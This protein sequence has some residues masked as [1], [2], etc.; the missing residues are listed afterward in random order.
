MLENFINRYCQLLSDVNFRR[1]Q[2]DL[3]Q[4]MYDTLGRGYALGEH[5]VPLVTRLTDVI[6][7]TE[8][9]QFNF[10]G[11]KI[12]GPRSYVEFD[13]RDKPVTK[14]IGDMA[15]ISIISCQRQRI[16]QKISFVQNKVCGD[17][18]WK[19]DEEQLFLLKNFPKFS[20]NKGIF[21]SFSKEDITFLNRSGCLGAF[22][23][24]LEPGEMMFITAPLLTELK[25]G[26]A[27]SCDDARFP[28]SA[29]M[30]PQSLPYFLDFR[31]L[32]EYLV[33]GRYPE[34]LLFLNAYQN[35][36]PSIFGGAVFS[37]DIYDFTRNWTQFN[38]GETTY[39]FGDITN[40]ILDKFTNFL[41]RRVGIPNVDLPHS[42]V[43]GEFENDMTLF[44]MHFDLGKEKPE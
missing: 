23:L 27:L 9:D 41:L 14:E 37:R 40:P 3:S 13:Y 22:G 21:R 10:Y 43:E 39:A 17:N 5:E 8:F 4:K 16:L 6:K 15:I 18:K 25:K 20:G 44:V 30:K 34:S 36:L 29:S 2:N 26:N 1:F 35:Q 32:H 7:K 19:I 11:E 24:F 33:R 28:E 38:I 12:H 31:Y 42:E